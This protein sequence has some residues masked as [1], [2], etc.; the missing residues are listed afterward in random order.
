LPEN[1]RCKRCTLLK[2][3]PL[4][5]PSFWADFCI[6]C[7]RVKHPVQHKKGLLRRVR[8][9]FYCFPSYEG[10][11]GTRSKTG[12][13]FKDS[14]VHCAEK[15]SFPSVRWNVPS[16]FS[17]EVCSCSA[18]LSL[19]PTFGSTKMVAFQRLVA[20][21]SHGHFIPSF[22]HSGRPVHMERG[23]DVHSGHPC[24]RTRFL[25]SKVA[26]MRHE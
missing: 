3:T 12:F 9:H 18:Q 10:K 21:L 13:V 4:A 2:I 25:L 22:V 1:E 19:Q 16:Q 8:F 24:G 17:S 11:T 15:K 6:W 20:G 26:R 14:I 5:V 7:K 23:A